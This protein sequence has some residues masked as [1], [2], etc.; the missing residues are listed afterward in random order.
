MRLFEVED[1][2]I[3]DLTTVLRNLLGRSDS[4]HASI[5]LTY[6]AISNLLSNM[7]YG[8]ISYDAFA[9]LYDENP[10]LKA[11]V[12]D[13]DADKVTLSTKTDAEQAPGHVDQDDGKSVDQMAHSAVS[14]GLQ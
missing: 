14:Q 1:N 4:K 9:K 6:K 8:E 3:V 13:F 2:V 7:G 10:A 11:I 12:G 5:V